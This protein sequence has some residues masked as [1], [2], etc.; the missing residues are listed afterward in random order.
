MNYIYKCGISHLDDL[1]IDES[2]VP[3]EHY[4]LV[5]IN[6]TTT[7][8]EIVY[9]ESDFAIII[10]SNPD[11]T[12][13]QIVNIEK[14][15]KYKSYKTLPRPQYLGLLKNCK[16]FISNSSDVYYIA[17]QWLK[18]EQIIQVGL[19]NKNRST[20]KKLETG[21]SQ[22]IVDILEKWWLNQNE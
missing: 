2:L 6:P 7:M 5:L 18:P 17:P 3:E 16:R 22:K 21:A 4:D 19:R 20:P 11:N 10:E 8:E 9:I 15:K 13:L 1:E 12:E 14:V